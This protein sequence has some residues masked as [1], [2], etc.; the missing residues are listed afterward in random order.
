MADV[1]APWQHLRVAGM[2]TFLVAHGAWSAGWAWKKMPSLLR[3]AGHD[4]LRPTYTGLGERAHL[5]HPAIDLVTHVEDVLSVLEYEDLRDVI[6]VGHSYGGMVATAVAARAPE[7]IARLVY[8]DAFVPRAGQSLFDLV[9]AEVSA[10]MQRMA[11][12][13][14]DGWKVPPNPMPPD[15]PAA[16]LAWAT[17]RRRP[18]PIK[19]FATPLRPGTPE[20]RQPRSYIACTRIGPFDVFRP[21]A[22]RAQR[23]GWRTFE[24][25]ASHNPHITAPPDLAAVLGAIAAARYGS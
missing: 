5:A 24:L 19:T 1:E 6:L 25:D 8:L 13:T 9:P 21:F 2:A 23:D 10:T 3:A 4:L 12:D 15:T 22:E 17:P 11:R 7:R 14:G 20:P 18:Q 16:D